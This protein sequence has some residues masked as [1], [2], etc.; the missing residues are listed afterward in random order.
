MN[1]ETEE[2]VKDL[3]A[4]FDKHNCWLDIWCEY[5]EDCRCDV[6]EIEGQA[7][8]KGACKISLN[9]KELEKYL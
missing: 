1:K 5:S 3:K 8:E 7:Q 6:V 9:I 2:F 4:V